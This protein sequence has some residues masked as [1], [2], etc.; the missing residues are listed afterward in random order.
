[1]GET[2]MSRNFE[3]LEQLET[4]FA[5][6]T[7]RKLQPPVY[8]RQEK[9]PSIRSNPFQQEVLRLVQRAFVSTNG[10]APRQVVFCGVDGGNGST[11]VCASAAR[12]LAATISKSVC[13]IDANLRSPSLADILQISDTTPIF[14]GRAALREGCLQIGSHLWFGGTDMLADD[15]GTLAPID[16][17]KERL[18]RLR[19]AFDFVLIDAPGTNVSEDAPKLGQLA[20]AAILVI[21]ANQTRRLTA[22]NAMKTLEASGVKLLGTVLHDRSFPIPDRLYR[23]L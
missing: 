8:T 10:T 17:L 16:K 9:A 20:D 11:S 6:T 22:R 1:M 14:G 23:R 12:A 4:G 21:D 15:G 7:D 18:A 19:E 13:V 3:L 2:A 5:T